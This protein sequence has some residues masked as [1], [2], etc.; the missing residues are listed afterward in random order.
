MYFSICLMASQMHGL[1]S[2]ARLQS[3]T[4]LKSVSCHCTENRCLC[5]LEAINIIVYTLHNY[6]LI[7][8]TPVKCIRQLGKFLTLLYVCT[9]L[10]NPNN[11]IFELIIFN[12]Q[13]YTDSELYF[14]FVS[15]KINCMHICYPSQLTKIESVQIH[16]CI[17][18]KSLTDVQIM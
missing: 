8:T 7:E 6:A 1:Q 5:T 2:H 16:F 9:Q 11:L 18:I 17:F 4:H 13:L 10:L 3:Y 12:T 14:D 15:K